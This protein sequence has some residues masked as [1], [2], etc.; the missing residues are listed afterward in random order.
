M[1]DQLTFWEDEVSDVS[2][3]AT[4]LSVGRTKYILD[5]ACGSRMFWF[6][7]EHP[8]TVFMD[9]READETL[10]D[11]RRLVIKPDVLG[12]FRNMPF[13]DET[14]RLVVFDPPHMVQLGK[15]SWLCKKYGKLSGESWK[16]DIAYGFRECFRVLK[17][18][19]VLVFKWCEEQIQLSKIIP[20]L[21]VPPLFGYR[22]G[23]VGKTHFLV[24]IKEKL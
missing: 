3:E 16:Q 17:P 22:G 4:Q 14:F 20:L 15:N 5:A 18:Y 23:K 12:D 10:C 19:G 7:R 8:H 11:G 13:A 1:D 2:P 9:N 24:F 6:N 21:P